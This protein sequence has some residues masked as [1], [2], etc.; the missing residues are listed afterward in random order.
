MYVY[1]CVYILIHGF[2]PA[3][4]E[5]MLRQRINIYDY[6]HTPFKSYVLKCLFSVE[7]WGHVSFSSL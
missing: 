7:F 5:V 4:L 3:S 1:V 6:C 2:L